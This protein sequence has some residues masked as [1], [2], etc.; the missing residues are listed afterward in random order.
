MFTA[1]R[2]DNTEDDK[3]KSSP[4][5]NN[6][7]K[8]IYLGQERTNDK[9]FSLLLIKK[10]IMQSFLIFGAERVVDEDVDAGVD[11]IT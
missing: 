6:D 2:S 10:K 4:W 8:L 3:K 5:K 1:C 7:P 9:Q 11:G